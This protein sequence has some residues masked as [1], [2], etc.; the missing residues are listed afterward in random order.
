MSGILLL[1]FVLKKLLLNKSSLLLPVIRTFIPRVSI[2]TWICM[3]GLILLLGVATAFIQLLSIILNIGSFV[4]QVWIHVL[5]FK[6]VGLVCN[7]INVLTFAAINSLRLVSLCFL[8]S[9]RRKIDLLLLWVNFVVRNNTSNHAANIILIR[10]S[11]KNRGDSRQFSVVWIIIPINCRDSVLRLKQICNRRVINNYNIIH[12][13]SQSGQILY[14]GIVIVGTVLS[15]EFIR[16]KLV[17]IKLK[18]QRL[19]ILGQTSRKNY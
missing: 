1:D 10:K 12:I 4:I 15:E 16:A 17:R 3:S 7:Q 19:C 8:V 13:P 14:K 5:F 18:H 9:C 11:L 6:F 2:L